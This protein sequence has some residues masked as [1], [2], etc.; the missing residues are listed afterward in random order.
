[1]ATVFH[2]DKARQYGS[3]SN[4]EDAAT[5]DEFFVLLK[6]AQDTLLD[7]VKRFAYDRFG[8]KVVI[9]PG[10]P[11]KTLSMATY[12]YEGLYALAPQYLVG[13]LLMVLLNTFWFSAW[14]RYVS[15]LFFFFFFFPIPISLLYFPG[16]RSPADLNFL[17]GGSIRF[18][19]C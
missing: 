17:S 15:G 11:N 6:L 10:E 13:F 8:A 19:H 2:P 1:M 7:P 3:G 9:R 18:L 4:A 14:G 12:F 5:V 16:G